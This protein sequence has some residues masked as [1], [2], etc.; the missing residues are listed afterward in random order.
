MIEPSVGRIVWYHP[1]VDQGGDVDGQPHA[2]IVAKVLDPRLIN[3]AVIN[4]NGSLYAR[5]NVVLLQDDD[6]ADPDGDYADWMPFQ[7]GQAVKT[8]A[9]TGDVAKQIADVASDVDA[10][11]KSLGDWLQPALDAINARIAGIELGVNGSTTAPVEPPPQA[12]EPQ[13]QA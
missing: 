9:A 1:H 10:K 11:F 12:A 13:A 3:L 7:K 6:A 5:Q 4:E 2:A 8:E